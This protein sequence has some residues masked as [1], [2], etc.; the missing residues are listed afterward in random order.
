MEVS[1]P[2]LRVGTD[3]GDK[4]HGVVWIVDQAGNMSDHQARRA[5]REAHAAGRL[6]DLLRE[7]LGEAERVKVVCHLFPQSLDPEVGRQRGE[8]SVTLA[9]AHFDSH[10]RSWHLARSNSTGLFF[11]TARDPSSGGLFE[12]VTSAQNPARHGANRALPLDGG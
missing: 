8:L 5:I 3:D 11:S 9:V 4:G 12:L 1:G 2:G 7:V 10:V 6:G